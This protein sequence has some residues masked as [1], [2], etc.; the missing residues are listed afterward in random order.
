MSAYQLPV[1]VWPTVVMGMGATAAWRG[2]DNE[3]LAASGVLA[4]WALSM[5]VARA[6]SNETQWGVFGVDVILL[7]LF[8][9]IA[10]RSRRFWP[11][12][13]AGFQLLMVFTHVA[14]LL[15]AG[16]S[17]WAYLTAKLVWSYLIVLTI[18][19]GAWTA[20]QRYAEI[21]EV[22]DGSAGTA[23]Q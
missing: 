23:P 13:V 5:V 20:P 11:L 14:R 18:A 17:G 1:Y 7:A 12:F 10:L 19:Y 15:D 8:L 3:R 4:G 6:R 22:G 9:W 2:S 21:A 16:V